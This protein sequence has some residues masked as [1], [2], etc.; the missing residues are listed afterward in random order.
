[1]GSLC[2]SRGDNSGTHAKEK[3]IWKA[4]GINPEGQKWYQETGLGMGQ[5]LNVA[6][7]KKGYT[8]ADRGPILP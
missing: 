7:E 2:L 1:A 3:G 6:A 8:L 4:A 5:T